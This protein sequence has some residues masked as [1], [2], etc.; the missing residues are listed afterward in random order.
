VPEIPFSPAPPRAVPAPAP[1][2]RAPAPPPPPPDPL[3]Q[4]RDSCWEEF[5]ARD[6][7]GRIGLFLETLPDAEVI[8]NDMAFEMLNVIH[9]DAATSGQRARF[10]ECLTALRTRR[11][12]LYDQ[13]AHNYLSWSVQDALAENRPET[14]ASLMRELAPR[15]GSQIDLFHRTIDA[16]EYHGQLSVLVESMRGAW[17]G[18]KTSK[19]IFPWGISEFA[20]KGA[21]YEIYD[22]LEHTPAPDPADPVLLDRIRFFVE[23]PRTEYLREFIL[24]LTGKSGREWRTDDFVLL[25]P[26][27][28]KRDAWDDGYEEDEEWDEEEEEYDEDANGEEGDGEEEREEEEREE[29]EREEEPE[30]EPRDPGLANLSRLIH[31]FVGYLRREEGVPFTR[32]ELISAELYRYF[33]RR[34]EG[35]LDPRPSMF[36]RVLHKKTLPKPPRPI[37]PLCPEHD[38][39]DVHLGGRVSILNGLFHTAAAQ[40]CVIPAWLRFLESRRL[41]DAPT[42]AAVTRNLLPLRTP[43][44]GLWERFPDD[45]ALLR[46]TQAAWPADAPKEPPGPPEERR[47]PEVR[48]GAPEG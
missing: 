37:H 26:E 10:A 44:V 7:E 13:G 29:E 25:P 1:P 31:E 14:V 45:P 11:P 23:K 16:L 4:K 20:E 34:H 47:Q 32:G 9:A 12:E 27:E 19:D 18:V 6:S 30:P 42:R 39:L 36:E 22:Y 24:D 21:N 46:D 40:F 35:E 3:T 41:I 33:V 38:T 28:R 43:L 15:A 2:W 5:E 48:P 17:P 8:T